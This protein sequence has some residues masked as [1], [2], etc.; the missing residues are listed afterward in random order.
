MRFRK[1]L[2]S[3]RFEG[4]NRPQ[5]LGGAGTRHRMAFQYFSSRLVMAAQADLVSIDLTLNR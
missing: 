5:R 3:S 1:P 4:G 2:S